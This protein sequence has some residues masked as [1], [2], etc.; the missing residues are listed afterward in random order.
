MVTPILIRDPRTG[1]T[2]DPTFFEGAR[3]TL[4]GL[5][6]SRARLPT[7]RAQASYTPRT[8]L[9]NPTHTPDYASAQKRGSNFDPPDT[10]FGAKY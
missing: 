6:R 3:I 7:L 2:A 9:H 8:Q 1:V 10:T 4:R 5:E